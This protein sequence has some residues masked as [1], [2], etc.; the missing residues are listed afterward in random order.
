MLAHL[1]GAA[2]HQQKEGSEPPNDAEREAK[3]NPGSGAEKGLD[4]EL[5]SG[6][7]RERGGM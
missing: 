2:N 7:S 6:A 4:T 1:R 5:D 3:P